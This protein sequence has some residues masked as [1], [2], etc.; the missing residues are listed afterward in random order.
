[1][2]PR[3]FQRFFRWYCHPKLVD[4]IEGDLLEAYQR[5]VNKIG[6]RKADVRFIIDVVSL[7]RRHIIRPFS[8]YRQ[9]NSYGMLKNYFKIGLRNIL[10]HKINSFI[11]VS[12]LAVGMSVCLCIMMIVGDHM[13]NDRYNSKRSRV[14]R[15]YSKPI[16]MEQMQEYATTP[17]GIKEELERSLPGLESVVRFKRSFQSDWISIKEVRDEIPLSGFYADAG[18]LELFEYELERGNPHTALAKPFSVVLTEKTAAKLFNKVDPTGETIQVGDL[19]LF[20]VT[21]VLRETGKKSHIQF[22]A[23]ASM[24]SGESLANS[25]TKVQQNEWDPDS[26]CWTYLL[27][28]EGK[29]AED[30]Q[31]ALDKIS[32]VSYNEKGTQKLG[33]WQF[34]LQNIIGI[35]PGVPKANEIGPFLGLHF[36]Y[37]VAGLS[38]IVLTIACFNFTNISIARSLKRAKEIGIRKVTGATRTQIFLQFLIESITISWIAFIVAIA[39]V[40]ALKTELSQIISLNNFQMNLFTNGYLLLAFFLFATLVGVT[41]GL[42]PGVILSRLQPIKV[43]KNLFNARLLNKIRLRKALVVAQFSISLIFI[44]TAIVVY[45]QLSLFTRSDYGFDMADKL[46][47][48]LGQTKYQTAKAELSKTTNIVNVSAVSHAPTTRQITKEFKGKVDHETKSIYCYSVDEDYLA[49]MRVSIVAG[50]NFKSN[51]LRSNESLVILNEQALKELQFDDP[52]SALG[53]SIINQTDTANFKIIGIVKDY[54][55]EILTERIRPMAWLYKPNDFKFLQVKYSGSKEEAI[56]SLMIAWDKLNTGQKLNLVDFKEE[57]LRPYNEVMRG[58]MVSLMIVAI[59][60]VS[61]SCLGLLGMAIYTVES[62]V[63]EIA[64]RKVFGSTQVSLVYSVSRSFLFMILFSIAIALPVSWAVN[65]VW[66]ENLAYR[67]Q[68][69]AGVFAASVGVLLFAFGCT[70]L[71]QTMKAANINPA[72]TLKNE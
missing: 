28:E 5:R 61:I 4:H 54:N 47:V 35:S 12:G 49:N 45:N 6:K 19:G 55:H 29:K 13:M 8:G 26:N 16:G 60:A 14:F 66:L 11:N 51:S 48:R 57:I 50:E 21:G 23:L 46:L 43:L 58:V 32:S 42:F 10:A 1:M 24:S 53:E 15:L 67:T 33:K 38:L 7:L 56:K 3:I 31:R 18:A 69:T 20:T 9:L 62:K 70:L 40:F 2:P 17:L 30:V 37:L 34:G 25:K 36:V 22:E 63:K 64:I 27:L 39:F 72:E 71:T 68:V 65:N 52:S 59:V 44:V 41:A